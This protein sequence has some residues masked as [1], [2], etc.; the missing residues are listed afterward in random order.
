MF[1]VVNIFGREITLYAIFSLIGIF[2]A[3]VLACRMTKK[4]GGD[5]NNTIIVLCIASVGVL[6]G[7]HL[8]Y[9]L[10]QISNFHLFS[11]VTD[12]ESFLNAVKIVFGGAVFYGGLIMGLIVGV[13]TV[14]VMKLPLKFYADIASFTIPLFHCFARIGCFFGGCC[15]GVESEFGF[16]AHNNH[17]VP[18]VNDVRRFPVQI[19]ESLLNLAIFFVIF[20]LFKKKKC[21]GKLLFIYFI[22]YSI[23]RF[24]NEFLRGDSIRGFVLGL[25][26]S[27]FISI[28]VFVFGVAGLIFSNFKRDKKS[29]V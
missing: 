1:P 9:G 25:S 3:G 11:K 2:V 27:Q 21:E 23:V 5:D 15:Y 17:L 19:L 7:G 18:M 16:I 24:L 14:K 20:Y 22:L 13:I 6:L 26:T 10:T 28:F 29:K 4:R 12:F 8:L